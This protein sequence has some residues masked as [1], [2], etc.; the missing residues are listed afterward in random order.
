M[1]VNISNNDIEFDLKSEIYKRKLQEIQT[2]YESVY[3]FDDLESDICLNVNGEDESVDVQTSNM[4][5]DAYSPAAPGFCV[6]PSKVNL[7]K[8]LFEK[9]KTE[10]DDTGES[11]E[12]P[13]ASII[14]YNLNQKWG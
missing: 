9:F 10:L 6:A 8:Y 2:E 1:K 12:C 4:D 5:V 3:L 7:L 11:F 14:P 13:Q